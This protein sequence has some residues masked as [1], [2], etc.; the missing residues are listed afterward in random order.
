MPR[1]GNLDAKWP[2]IDPGTGGLSGTPA[3]SGIGEYQI[4]VRV[5]VDG[6]EHV[7]SF[8]LEVN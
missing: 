3:A 1:C 2:K 5:R 7:Q 4:N 8:P 6:K